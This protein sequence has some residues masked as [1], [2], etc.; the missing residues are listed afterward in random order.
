MRRSLFQS[1]GVIALLAGLVATACTHPTQIA[2]PRSD[3]HPTSYQVQLENACVLDILLEP[4]RV[5]CLRITS[6]MPFEWMM[7]RNNPQYRD[8]FV[9][10][11]YLIRYTAPDQPADFG[12]RLTQY[13]LDDNNFVV[14]H[15]GGVKAC[16][17]M[18]GVAF[19]YCRGDR[20]AT[21]LVCFQCGDLDLDA[22]HDDAAG[23]D[24]RRDFLPS[25]LTLVSFAKEAFPDDRA[26]QGLP[27][28]KNEV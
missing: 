3:L 16:G 10:G 28:T 19:R 24:G 22:D 15:R 2:A 17:F 20:S 1:F 5:E 11:F 8:R 7:A 23:F 21:L 9:A 4:E 18:P 27:A 14:E 25:Y 13:L 26:I 6:D 12:R